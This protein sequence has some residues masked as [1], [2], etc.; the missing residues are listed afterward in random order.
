MILFQ[1]I[2]NGAKLISMPR[3][4]PDRFLELVQEHKVN[5]LFI[6]PPLAVFL[7]KSP[8]VAKYSLDSVTRIMCGAAPLGEETEKMVKA[9]CPN[10]VFTQG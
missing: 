9:K 3:F 5:G 10:A 4:I 2:F 8:L 7:A 6:A 1:G